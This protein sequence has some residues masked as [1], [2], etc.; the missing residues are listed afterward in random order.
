MKQDRGIGLALGII[1]VFVCAIACSRDDVNYEHPLSGLTMLERFNGQFIGTYS[2]QG[3]VHHPY[4][5]QIDVV[6]DTLAY[7]TSEHYDSIPV[8][9]RVNAHLISAE[10]DKTI[11]SDFLYHDQAYTLQFQTWD[12]WHFYGRRRIP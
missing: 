6:N 8:I 7:M 5:I 9:F 11:F 12:F 1:I 2:R 4:V 3:E 10:R